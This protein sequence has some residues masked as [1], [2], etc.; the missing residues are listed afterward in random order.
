MKIP[1]LRGRARANNL[2]ILETL[3]SEG[4]LLK[5][6][7]HKRLKKNGIAEYS[8]VTR[9]IDSLRKKGYLDVA[10]RRITE[11]GKRKAESMYGLTWKGFIASLVS[12][13]VR[14]NA[15]QVIERNPLLTFPE[16]ELV[17]SVLG[18]IFTQQELDDIITSIL[19]A[20][21]RVIPNL[22]TLREENLWIWLL[23]IREIPFPENF[24]LSKLP[25]DS[26]ELLDNSTI[27]QIIKQ[28]ILPMISEYEER[29]YVLFQFFKIL[30]ELGDFIK[31][32]QPEDK[33]SKRLKEHLKTFRLEEKLR[34]LEKQQ[35]YPY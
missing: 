14:R 16:K 7:V 17:I 18:E 29:F 30:N 23:E 2:L 19:A 3:A 22:E 13:N 11:R 28:R 35:V 12:E 9:R 25:Q 20:Y 4:S 27:L 8:T 24:Q 1:A 6:D 21:L 15:L 10:G 5:Y 26:L 32:L 31:K 34:E 33:P